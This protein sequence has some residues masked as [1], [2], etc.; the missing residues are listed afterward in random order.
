VLSLTSARVGALAGAFISVTTVPA[1]GNVA[2]GLAFGKLAEVRGSALQLGVNI[3]GMALAGWLTLV[4]QRT[5]WNR[6]ADRRERLRERLS[7][8]R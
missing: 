7:R 8:T 3:V 6:F 4:F 1:A 2:L 5:V